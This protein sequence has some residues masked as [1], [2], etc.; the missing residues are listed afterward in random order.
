MTRGLRGL[1]AACAV[2]LAL[3]AQPVRAEAVAGD[4]RAVFAAAAEALRARDHATAFDLFEVLAEKN[5]P[6]AQ[7]ILSALLWEGR[8]RTRNY[9]EALYWALLARLE[10]LVAVDALTLAITGDQASLLAAKRALEENGQIGRSADAMIA[11]LEA[12][13]LP[14][15]RDAVVD[16]IAARIEGQIA[17]GRR[18]AVMK[19]G[20]LNAELRAE[21][22]LEAAYVWFS[23]GRAI[24]VIGAQE[25]LDKVADALEPEALQA[26]QDKAVAVFDASAFARAQPS[27][28]AEA[29]AAAPATP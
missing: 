24:G 27:P 8:G 17:E 10:T 20:I 25:R 9:R 12:V 23:V 26:A 1:L 15:Q 14:E 11:R 22:D 3:G 18:E 19:F 16:R 6:E 5:L 13:V 29:P 21:P 2:L 7:Y 28:T 4:D